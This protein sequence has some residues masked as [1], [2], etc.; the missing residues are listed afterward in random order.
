M[1][2]S[3]LSNVLKIGEVNYELSYL[4]NVEGGDRIYYNILILM[5]DLS[6]GITGTSEVED[7]TSDIEKV[8]SL[9][10]KISSGLVTPVTLKD[11]IEDYLCE[12]YSV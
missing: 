10:N 9:F 12:E 11:I 5:K 8:K 3:K 6:N 1:T 4:L 2:I 7:I